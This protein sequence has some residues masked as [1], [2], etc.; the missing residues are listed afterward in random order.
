VRDAQLAAA[1]AVGQVG[2][3]VHLLVGRVAGR[4]AGAL[5]RQRDRAVA[6]E[7]VRVHVALEPALKA[8]GASAGTCSGCALGAH[9]LGQLEVR[10][11]A[12][13]LGLRDDVRRARRASRSRMLRN[14]ALHVVD[15][16]LALG[17]DEDLD[18]RLVHVVAPAVAVV[19]AHDRLDEDEDL[20]PRQGSRDRRCRSP[21]CGPCRRRPAP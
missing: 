19:D 16:A 3:E 10:C 14:S 5:E 21:A 2:G 20:L 15:E 9:A 11:D 6:G 18:A 17:L 12:V 8:S 4:L 13:E 7:L 1:V